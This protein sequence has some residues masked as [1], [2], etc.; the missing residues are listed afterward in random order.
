[1]YILAA[2]LL[3]SAGML[4]PIR[5]KVR[6]HSPSPPDP[7]GASG[8]RRGRYA[9][10]TAGG[11]PMVGTGTGSKFRTPY[12]RCVF[13]YLL[14]SGGFRVLQIACYLQLIGAVE[15]FAVFFGF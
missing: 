13:S 7:T 11:N 5:R 14:G 9:A 4:E 3:V 12:K 2:A 6:G 15:N 10:L 1:M 8:R